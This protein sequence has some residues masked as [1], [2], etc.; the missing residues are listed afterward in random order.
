V[1]PSAQE[2]RERRRANWTLLA[3]VICVIA[4]LTGIL[5]VLFLN[6]HSGPVAPPPLTPEAK[7]YTKYLGL[8]EV[9]MKAK[10]SFMQSTLVEITGKIT[11]K[12]DRSLRLVE[13]NCVFY[14]PIGQVALRERVAIVRQKDGALRPGQTRV[15][16]LPFDAIPQS[17]N[18]ILPQLV[19]ARIDFVE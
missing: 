14:D 15:F 6:G 13:I 5:Y 18:Q 11:N 12:G 16:R 10:D 9:E 4:V 17:W 1:V 7:A 8:S 3:S 2:I 19:I